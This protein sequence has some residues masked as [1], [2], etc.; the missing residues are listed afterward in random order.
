MPKVSQ[1]VSGRSG[2]GTQVGHP[3]PKYRP[4]YQVADTTCLFSGGS[5]HLLPGLWLCVGVGMAE[6]AGGQEGGGTG[7]GARLLGAMLQPLRPPPGPVGGLGPWAGHGSS[8]RH[9]PEPGIPPL[10]WF[11]ALTVAPT[12]LP[13]LARGSVSLLPSSFFFLRHSD[14]GCGAA[15]TLWEKLVF[16]GKLW[17]YDSEDTQGAASWCQ[18]AAC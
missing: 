3:V 2:I 10:S 1:L 12:L 14:L 5:G 7:R 4:L 17:R 6:R 13:L 11:L 16:V 9:L 18:G 8:W 15:F